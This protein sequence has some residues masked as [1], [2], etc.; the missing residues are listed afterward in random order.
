MADLDDDDIK[1]DRTATN[2]LGA[3]FDDPDKLDDLDDLDDFGDEPEDD[4]DEDEE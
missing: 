2:P 4:E 1:D 3:E